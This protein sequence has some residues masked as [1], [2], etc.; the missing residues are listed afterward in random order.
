MKK[1]TYFCDRCK[2]EIEGNPLKIIV[3]EATHDTEDLVE[4]IPEQFE[5]I[6]KKHFCLQ[7]TERVIATATG[8]CVKKDFDDM[9]GT[10]GEPEP[11]MMGGD[12]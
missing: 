3:E 8:L 6:R 1:V 7:C 4:E 2:K 11:P 10:L 9:F 12:E 5:P